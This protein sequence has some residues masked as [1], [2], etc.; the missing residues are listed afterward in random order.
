M[1]QRILIIDDEPD[2]TTLFCEV[3]RNAGHDVRGFTNP[4][5]AYKEFTRNPDK[6]WLVI[7][8]VRMPGMSGIELAIKVKEKFSKMKVILISA[9]EIEY[10]NLNDMKKIDYFVSKPISMEK[11]L[12][13]VNVQ[14]KGLKYA[15]RALLYH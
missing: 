12:D 14:F 3:F 15:K 5:K 9:F 2:L 10:I 7:T 13:I 6:Y 4:V 11:L 1:K 8:D